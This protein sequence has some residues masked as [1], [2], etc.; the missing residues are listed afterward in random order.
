MSNKSKKHAMAAGA[1]VI[2]I[3]VLVALFSIYKST[4]V[5]S[6]ELPPPP[7]TQSDFSGIDGSISQFAIDNMSFKLNEWYKNSEESELN[8]ETFQ[9]FLDES[10][11]IINKDAFN[12]RIKFQLFEDSKYQLFSAGE[13]KQE[14]TKDD[15]I[16][17]YVT[18]TRDLQ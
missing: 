17:T 15:Y 4:P 5:A 9:K 18:P 16:K 3:I 6:N 12:Q 13:D 10:E 8:E 11:D 2:L 1:V 14:K 7:V